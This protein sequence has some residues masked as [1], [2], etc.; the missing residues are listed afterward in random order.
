[1]R[2]WKGEKGIAR[3]A[4]VRGFCVALLKIYCFGF[5]LGAVA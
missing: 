1:M 3:V 2:W 5:I 4:L